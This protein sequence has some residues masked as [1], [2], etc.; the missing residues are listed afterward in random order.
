MGR[1]WM[2][3]NLTV[4]H[5]NGHWVLVELQ[6]KDG[7]KSYDSQWIGIAQVGYDFTGSLSF[8]E[9]ETV[10]DCVNF[11]VYEDL[12]S[13]QIFW[14]AWNGS[15][16]F[17]SA[18]AAVSEYFVTK[19]TLNTD[20]RIEE[21][22]DQLELTEFSIE[23]D[24]EAQQ[25]TYTAYLSSEISTLG[26]YG[27]IYRKGTGGQNFGMSYIAREDGCLTF[28]REIDHFAPVGASGTFYIAH[29]Y[30]TFEEAGDLVCHVTQSNGY[31]YQF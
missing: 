11:Y 29:N 16:G 13:Q 18:S 8:W 28:T 4:D 27:L 14:G 2:K 15:N 24:E 1:L 22:G 12:S 20:I 31:S 26:D 10:I 21:T 5:P 23:R 7:S 9:P 30:F 19:F 6:F 25:E 17:D 3:S